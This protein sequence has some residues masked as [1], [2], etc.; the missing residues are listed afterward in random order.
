MQTIGVILISP[1]SSQ[2][3]LAHLSETFPL[4][5]LGLKYVAGKIDSIHMDEDAAARLA[6]LKL[7]EKSIKVSRDSKPC[8]LTWNRVNRSG[9]A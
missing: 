3:R 4:A 9:S 6:L 7:Y 5:V 8:C 2:E 1:A